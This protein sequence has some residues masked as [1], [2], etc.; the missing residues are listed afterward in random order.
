MLIVVVPF[1]Y[2]QQ[3]SSEN[4]RAVQHQQSNRKIL[5]LADSAPASKNDSLRFKPSQ[6]HPSISSLLV[7]CCLIEHRQ[8]RAAATAPKRAPW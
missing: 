3:S 1:N 6:S 2:S 5:S 8:V 7:D 4:H